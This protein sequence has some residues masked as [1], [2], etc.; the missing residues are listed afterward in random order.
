MK[1]SI[2]LTI[3]ATLSLL[4][5]PANGSVVYSFKHI[6]EEHDG[7]IEFANGQIG[8]KQLF[9][10]VAD[11]FAHQV[12]FTFTN[13]GPNPCSITDIYF[14]D[15]ELFSMASID[16]S[17]P[18]VSFSQYASPHNLPGGQNLSPPFVTTEGFSADSN[19]PV[20][21]NGINPDEWLGITFNIKSGRSYDDVISDLACGEL[22]IG[23]HVQGFSNYMCGGSE[24][25]VNVPEPATLTILGLGLA[26]FLRFPKRK[27]A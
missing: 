10:E 7:P 16:D 6:A 22:R 15:G 20:E 25:F 17:C 11:H 14:D 3:I 21:H 2:M 26:A 18:G 23:L 19:P 12:L 1:K 5:L 9:V 27:S 24:S 13:T 4:C 8:E